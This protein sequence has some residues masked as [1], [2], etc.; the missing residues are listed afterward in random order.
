MITRPSLAAKSPLAATV[1]DVASWWW[2]VARMSAR[3]GWDALPGPWPVKVAL[4]LLL[5]AGQLVPGELD[6]LLLIFL[7]GYVKRRMD[8]RKVPVSP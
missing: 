3:S 7:I 5:I 4:V 1:V 8:A 6:E 2:C